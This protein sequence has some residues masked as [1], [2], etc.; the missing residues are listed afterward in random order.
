LIEYLGSEKNASFFPFFYKIL[1]GFLSLGL[2]Q[3]NVFRHSSGENPLGVTP[4]TGATWDQAE[5]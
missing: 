1:I 3:K 4:Y 5:L 2:R